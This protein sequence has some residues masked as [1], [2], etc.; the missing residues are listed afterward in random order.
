MIENSLGDK[1]EDFNLVIQGFQLKNPVILK[2]KVG[3]E[4]KIMKQ[5]SH[6][7][8]YLKIVRDLEFIEHES[9]LN[10]LIDLEDQYH[11][12][13]QTE[14]LTKMVSQTIIIVDDIHFETIMKDLKVENDK[15]LYVVKRSSLEVFETY[16]INEITVQENLGRLGR[17]KHEMIWN[18]NI[19]KSFVLRRSNF[20]GMQIKAMTEA[21]GVSLMLDPLFERQASY[22]PENETYLVNNFVSG[23]NHDILK[24]LENELNFTTSLYKRKDGG[25]GYV[26]KQPN[27]TYIAS[28]MVGDLFYQRADMIVAELTLT[29]N[30]ATFI[31]FM[32]AMSTDD[33]GLFLPSQVTGMYLDFDVFLA[34]FRYCKIYVCMNFPSFCCLLAFLDLNYG[35]WY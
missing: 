33:T 5:M 35:L 10:L 30:R 25:W 16:C 32:I 9:V 4:T 28:G 27:G 12:P 3:F 13:Y 6:Q 2:S 18:S 20:H 7:M 31:D 11:F 19:E 1:V 23:V 21:T 24:F 8:Q 29:L 22:F 14:T 34:P 15:K 26:S 17:N